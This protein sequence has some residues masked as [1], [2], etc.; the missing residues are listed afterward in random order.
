MKNVIQ[1]TGILTCLLFFLIFQS[2]YAQPSN[3][4]CS[5]AIDISEAFIGSCGD[6][7]F[8]GPFDLTGSTPG[9]DDPPEPG[10]AEN[11]FTS[12]PYCPEETDSN[13]FGDDSEIWENSIWFTFTVPDL[14]GDGSDVV[15]SLWTSDGSFDDNCGIN[16]N[17][18]LEGDSD[19]QVAIYEGPDCPNSSTGECDHYAAS[20]DL[21]NQAPW[22]SGWENI[23]FTPGVSYY[24]A[25]DGWD[26]A[27]GE[28]CITVTICGLECG[29]G[30]C[31]TDESYCDCI[32]DCGDN[33][34]ASVIYGIDEA[35]NGNVQSFDWSGNVLHCSE[36]VLGFNNG[37]LYLTLGGS[38]E[39]CVQ[40]NG[41]D[42]PVDLS[43][44][45]LVNTDPD[46]MDTIS[47][48]FYTYIE[49]TP[50]DMATGSITI[51]STQPDGLGNICSDSFTID[52]TALEVS[53]NISCT[54]GGI[55]T[56]LLDNDIIVCEGQPF[57]LSTDGL[58]NLTLP[59]YSDNGSPYVYAWRLLID[60]YGIGDFGPVNE[61]QPLGTN[62]TIDPST[63][64]IDEFGY[65]PPYFTP[66]N[67]ISPFDYYTGQPIVFQIQ[68]AVV[69]FNSDGTIVNICTAATGIPFLVLNYAAFCPEVVG[70]TGGG[71]YIPFV[72]NSEDIPVGSDNVTLPGTTLSTSIGTIYNFIFGSSPQIPATT[73][74]TL[75]VTLLYLSP[76]DIASGIMPTLTFVDATGTCTITVT[77][78]TELDPNQCTSCGLNTPTIVLDDGSIST[79]ICINDGIDEPV[80]IVITDDGSGD[81]SAWIITDIAGNILALPTAQ[82]PFILDGADEGECLIWLIYWCGTLSEMLTVGVNLPSVIA[83]SD[84]V[85]SNPISVTRN[86]CGDCEEEITGI[87]SPPDQ[88]CDVS[89]IDITIIAPDG[90][91]IN[92]TTAADGSFT[93]PGGPFLCGNY[94][95]AFLDPSQLPAC[96]T[97][98]GSQ[99]PVT[100]TLD[101]ADNEDYDFVFS[102]T[103]DIPTLSQ[104]IRLV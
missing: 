91:T 28:F 72:F 27:Q 38:E 60:F 34:P 21:Y 6:F 100:I 65:V 44:G 64:F 39:N 30:E 43:I 9:L 71:L 86:T 102:A 41:L 79:S 23:Q 74:A 80:D 73:E 13:L 75:N 31:A 33:C 7:T 103:A 19:T 94:I 67:P 26:G 14:Y 56:D 96:Y 45:S 95:A 53:C 81:E 89:G 70:A 4:E 59:C 15:Y 35:E 85:I 16:P 32:A 55:D 47:A 3:D 22:I 61:W 8:N 97:D 83:A 62:P 12:G 63:F 36:R 54:A 24:M 88:G 87:I 11:D 51:T 99:D 57:S 93:V 101:G 25:I 104:W 76:A 92:V 29:N 78:D 10:E 68:G 1:L 50:A 58:E 52:L 49:L 37:N 66:G 48:G 84:A 2:S 18:M 77:I 90:T 5:G 98:T 20:E 40:D 42:L 17:N 82:P 46:G 69:C